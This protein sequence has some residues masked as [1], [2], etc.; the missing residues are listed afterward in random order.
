MADLE[1][2]LSNLSV[3]QNHPEYVLKH[4]LLDPTSEVLVQQVSGWGQKLAFLK[5]S[6][7]MLIEVVTGFEETTNSERAH[8]LSAF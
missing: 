8:P 5:S 3:H 1:Q 6:Q 2:Y 7:V 4:P